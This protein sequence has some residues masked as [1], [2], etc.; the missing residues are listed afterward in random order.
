MPKNYEIDDVDLK[1]LSHLMQDAKTPYTEIAKKVY[2]SG[3]TVHVR[4]KKM[5]ELGV[6][7]GTTLQLD[8]SKLGFDVTCFLGIYLQKSSL[9]DVVVDKLRDIPEVVKI[10][11]TTGNYNIFIKIHC[12]DTN[13]LREVLHDK[14][15]KVDGIDR[16]ETFISL[17]E[18]M[19]RPIQLG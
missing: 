15:Q 2:V 10:H 9:Y 3:G 8:Y 12:R 5:E 6:V 18:S 13:H 7:K 14:I 11:Y 16:T 19:S 1:I 4:M 17:D